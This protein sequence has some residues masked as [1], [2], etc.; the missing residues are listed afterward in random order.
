MGFSGVL[1]GYLW[2]Y[3]VMWGYMGLYGVILCNVVFNASVWG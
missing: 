1:W 3:G 2:L